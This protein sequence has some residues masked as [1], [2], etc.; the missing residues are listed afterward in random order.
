MKN[1]IAI[2]YLIMAL[3]C[4]ALQQV[5]SQEIYTAVAEGNVEMTGN[6]LKMIRDF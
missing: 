1:F 6:F 3:F 5:I 4:I 2:R